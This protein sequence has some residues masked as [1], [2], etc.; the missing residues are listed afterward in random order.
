MR[1][2]RPRGRAMVIG[3]VAALALAAAGTVAGAAFTAVSMTDAAS[4]HAVHAT[5]SQTAK[6]RASLLRYLHEGYQPEV[7][8]VHDGLRPSGPVVKA[9]SADTGSVEAYNWGGYADYT[10]TANTFTAVSGTFRQPATV[11]TAEQE[12]TATWVGLDG[13]S[14]DTVEQDG[15]LAYCFEGVP[16]YY[17][18]W[19]IYPAASVTVGTSVQPGDLITA[20]VTRS[21]TSYTLSITD[22]NNPANSFSTVQSCTTCE[23]ESAEWIVERPAFSIGITPLSF[24]RS[25]HLT[26]ASET[27]N[28]TTGSIASGPNAT[29]ITMVDATGTYALATVSPLSPSGTSFGARWLNSY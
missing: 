4:Q 18:W 6:A 16:Y 2:R 20:S 3:S 12:L 21:G 22:A 1:V 25:W 9:G 28:G 13:Y 14:T 17:T 23:N 29:S 5:A 19:E 8:L 24:F 7:N 11:C 10:S 27:A 26:G 15:T